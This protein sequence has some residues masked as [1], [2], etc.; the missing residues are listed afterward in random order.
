MARERGRIFL[1]A[2]QGGDGL[3]KHAAGLQRADVERRVDR[4]QQD[5]FVVKLLRVEE[6]AIVAVG[7]LAHEVVEDD[8]GRFVDGR[9][10]GFPFFN[11]VVA[12]GC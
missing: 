9:G 7:H 6:Q 2:V 11:S 4:T 12:F 3:V 8:I 1:A 5:S 10:A